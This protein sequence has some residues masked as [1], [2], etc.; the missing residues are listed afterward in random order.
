MLLLSNTSNAGALG[1]VL[2]T[3]S[4][5]SRATSGTV[6]DGSFAAAAAAGDAAGDAAGGTEGESTAKRHGYS[7]LYA[8][9]L[10]YIHGYIQSSGCKTCKQSLLYFFFTIIFLV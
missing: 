6:A 7:S 3:V 4:S 9:T 5:L 8:F 10:K 1:Q 2:F